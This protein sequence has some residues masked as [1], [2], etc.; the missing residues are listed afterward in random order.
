MDSC[1]RVL[2]ADD[3][4]DVLTLITKLAREALNAHVTVT[5]DGGQALACLEEE[6]YAF[7]LLL[8]DVDM[9]R[10]SGLDVLSAVTSARPGL[11]VVLIS[12]NPEHAT[13]A[14]EFGARAFVSK[15]RPRGDLGRV[16]REAIA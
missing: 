2:V 10:A 7:D 11:P 15:P 9:P 4:P 13:P 8:L 16:L 5:R 14:A 1:T 6:D 3:H 12:G